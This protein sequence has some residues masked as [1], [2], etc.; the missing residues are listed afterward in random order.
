MGG[1]LCLVSF[2]VVPLFDGLDIISVCV[3]LD[4]DLDLECNKTVLDA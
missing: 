3:D 1:K 2:C 4:L